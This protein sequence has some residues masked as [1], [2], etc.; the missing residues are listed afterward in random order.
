MRAPRLILA[1]TLTVTLTAIAAPR[2]VRAQEMGHGPVPM[3]IPAVRIQLATDTVAV[4]MRI[5]DGR[6]VVDV[7]LEGK[8][9]F[10]FVFDSGAHGSVMDLEFAKAQGISLGSQVMVGSPGG[11]GR[12]GQ[13]ATVKRLD[14]GGLSLGDVTIVA[15]T[16]LPFKDADPPRGVLGPY[17]WSGLLITFDY[18]HSRLVFRR[19][20]LPEPDGREIF[21]WSAQQPL[22]LVP[23]TVAGQKIDANLDTG[24]RYSLSLPT[25]FE[26]TLPLAGPPVDAGRARTVDQDVVAQRAT[27]KGKVTIGRYTLEN[28]T[29]MFSS[30]HQDVCNVGPPL[31]RQFTFTLDPANRR[32]RLE[33][34]ANGKLIDA[35]PAPSKM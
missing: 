35:E 16:G 6:V 23:I 31:L 26:K 28:P 18:S 5:V 2:P 33:G 29:L 11:A 4:P 12:P 9:P 32:L 20:S 10:P 25:S 1:M 27:L 14:V 34:P 15:F 3:K 24:A 8:G 17:S 7:M 13:L 19:G 21:G 30:L 22:P